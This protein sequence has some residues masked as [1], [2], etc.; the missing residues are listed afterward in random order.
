MIAF[1]FL[2]MHLMLDFLKKSQAKKSPLFSACTHCNLTWTKQMK[3]IYKI[4]DTF[5]SYS[6]KKS[7]FCTR[8]QWRDL[9][10]ALAL[11]RSYR[12]LFQTHKES[13]PN[14]INFNHQREPK[15]REKD[16]RPYRRER[17][18]LK[19]GGRGGHLGLGSL[20]CGR[21]HWIIIGRRSK[22]F[23]CCYTKNI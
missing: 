17:R 7:L 4:L 21:H 9:A 8:E 6:T 13:N 11:A 15:C 19:R 1:L 23:L 14:N 10:L 18:F 20:G 3:L 16:N 22:H 12:C 2:I 5:I